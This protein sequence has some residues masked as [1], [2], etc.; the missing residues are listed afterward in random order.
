MPTILIVDD[1]DG[2]LAMLSL[3]LERAGYE[4]LKASDGQQAIELYQSCPADLVLADLVMP[5]KEGLEM[6]IELTGLYPAVKI[7]AMTGGRQ[8]FLKV[9]KILGAKRVLAKPFSEQEIL[10]AV[11]EVLEH[12]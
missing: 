9:A 6:I 4:V 11:S 2:I 7:I 5:N 8:E 10:D 12:G 3:V 1:D